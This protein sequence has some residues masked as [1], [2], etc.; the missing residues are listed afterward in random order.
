MVE[1]RYE[2]KDLEMI[3][4]IWAEKLK[5]ALDDVPE[6]WIDTTFNKL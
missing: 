5:C 1:H 4:N 2:K 3:S 6:T